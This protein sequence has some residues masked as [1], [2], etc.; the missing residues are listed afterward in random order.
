MRRAVRRSQW[1]GTVRK[2]RMLE[3]RRSSRIFHLRSVQEKC[4][5]SSLKADA[6]CPHSLHEP[7]ADT[8][9]AEV[10]LGLAGSAF[11]YE[12]EHW[13]AALDEHDALFFVSVA[14]GV[15]QWSLHR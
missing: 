1:L 5:C 12:G 14:A 2:N 4:A 9:D 3:T 7:H 13:Y 11:E 10:F 6:T 8:D 15:S